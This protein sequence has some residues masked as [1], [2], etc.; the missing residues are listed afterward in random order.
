MRKRHG[1]TAHRMIDQCR[2]LKINP[3]NATGAE[4]SGEQESTCVRETTA[5]S[6]RF[7]NR[8]PKARMGKN[9]VVLSRRVI[10]ILGPFDHRFSWRPSIDST[11]HQLPQTYTVAETTRF[12]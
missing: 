5:D 1:T 9:P 4:K 12:D 3:S 11:A 7:G 10:N 6:R 2:R 8:Q